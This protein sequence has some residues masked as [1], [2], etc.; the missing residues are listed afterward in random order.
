MIIWYKYLVTK[1]EMYFASER[2]KEA[3][4]DSRVNTR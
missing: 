3:N 2:K 1:I 4:Y